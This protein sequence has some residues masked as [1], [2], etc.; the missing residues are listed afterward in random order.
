MFLCV[1]LFFSLIY[2]KE[3]FLR[4]KKTGIYVSRETYMPVS[5]GSYLFKLKNLFLTVLFLFVVYS[6]LVSFQHICILLYHFFHF[7]HFTLAFI[8][9]SIH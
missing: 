4:R 1:A 7:V 3:F 8:A 5:L 9:V 6:A 2:Q